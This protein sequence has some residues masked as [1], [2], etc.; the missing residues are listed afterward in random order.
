[1]ITQQEVFDV[2]N[3]DI[4]QKQLDTLSD[5]H[6][7]TKHYLLIAEELSLEGVAFLQP[8]KEHRDAYDHLM[9]IFALHRREELPKNF[10]IDFYITDNLKKAYGHAYR[11]FFD[12]ADWLTFICRRYIRSSLSNLKIRKKYE[13]AGHSFS[14][15]KKLINEVPWQIAQ[16]RE[17]KDISDDKKAIKEVEQYTETLDHLLQIYKDICSL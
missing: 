8:L 12:T 7:K 13:D 17:N 10:K 15:A 2:L 6:V 3:K 9:R 11:A 5:I 14:E 1:M 4:N 16:Y